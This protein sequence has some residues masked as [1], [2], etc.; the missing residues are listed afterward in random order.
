M[1]VDVAYSAG[2]IL[3]GEF[4]EL[5]SKNPND[6]FLHIALTKS[7]SGWIFLACIIGSLYLDIPGMDSDTFGMQT[8]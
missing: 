7:S 5:D 1:S 2:G 4:W 8:V 3:L 6:T